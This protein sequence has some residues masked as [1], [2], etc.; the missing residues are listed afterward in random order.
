[1]ELGKPPKQGSLSSSLGNPAQRVQ[2]TG[3]KGSQ[4]PTCRLVVRAVRRLSRAPRAAGRGPDSL[5]ST[6]VGEGPGDS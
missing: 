5:C 4:V 1:M 6:E 2:A 3:S